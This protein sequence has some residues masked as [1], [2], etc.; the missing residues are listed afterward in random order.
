M[1]T[2]LQRTRKTNTSLNKLKH[3][4]FEHLDNLYSAALIDATGYEIV[5]GYGKTSLEAVN[6]M[7]AR[8][9]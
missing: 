1:N 7:H 8:L 2:L 5:K 6:D 4:K 3:I 9:L